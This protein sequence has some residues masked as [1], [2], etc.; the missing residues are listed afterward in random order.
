[1]NKN[2]V[3]GGSLRLRERI[4]KPFTLADSRLNSRATMQT[5]DYEHLYR[6]EETFWWFAGMREITAVL[7]DPFLPP[8]DRVILDAGC[9]TGGNLEW[10]TRYAGG[11]RV[12]GIDLIATALEFCQKRNHERLAQASATDLPFADQSF[13]LVT[14]FDVLVQIPGPASDQ[15]AMREMFRVLKPGGIAFVRG[16]A[17]EWMKSGHDRAL[18]TQ[19]R[20]NL[21]ELREK[22]KRAGFEVL[23]E[24][25]ANSLLFPIAA[26]RRLL[27]KRLGLAD[28]GSDVK[29][30]PKNL[31]WINRILMNA[32]LWEARRL[33]DPNARLSVGLSAICI[34][35]RPNGH[36]E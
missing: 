29:P 13:D 27:L 33:R 18:G 8:R 24:T 32:L 7:L 30:L 11:G 23:R 20:Y 35:R 9:G 31:Q 1:M 34:A 15:Q 14:S 25:Y 21:D 5:E 6:L 2:A 26:I 4:A 17:F 28:E 36:H 19:R 16:A 10:L 3:A 22:L 12:T